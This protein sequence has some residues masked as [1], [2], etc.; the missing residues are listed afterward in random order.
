[1]FGCLLIKEIK[2]EKKKKHKMPLCGDWEIVFFL[3]KE[4][5]E[6][7]GTLVLDTF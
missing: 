4:D 6:I 5:W 1:M 7:V 3:K 2:L